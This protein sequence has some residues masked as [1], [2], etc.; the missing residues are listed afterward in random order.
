MT[1]TK[2][3][4]YRYMYLKVNKVFVQSFDTLDNEYHMLW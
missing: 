2:I 4:T 1:M 3:Y